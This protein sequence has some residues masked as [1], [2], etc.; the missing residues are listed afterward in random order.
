MNFEETTKISFSE[1]KAIMRGALK[2]YWR[3]GIVPAVIVALTVVVVAFLLPPYFTSEALLI[4]QPQRITSELIKKSP[5]EIK[6]EMQGLMEEISTEILSRA[7]LR[8]IIEKYDLY[9]EFQGVVGKEQAIQKF[10]QAI[11]LNP[12]VSSSGKEYVSTFSLSYT[13]QDAKTAFEVTKI[14]SDKFVEESMLNKRA[15]MQRTEEFLDSQ[16]AETRK[17]LEITEDQ[18]QKFERANFGRLPDYLNAAVARLQNLQAQID[19]NQKSIESSVQRKSQLRD[20][21]NSV[22]RTIPMPNG[23]VEVSNPQDGV[24]QL[25]AALVALRSRY[26]EQHP[27]VIATKKRL[28]ALKA[29]MAAG[30]DTHSSSARSGSVSSNPMAINIRS[31][32][33]KLE[34]EITTRENENKRLKEQVAK[35]QEDIEAMPTKDQEMIKIKR[36]YENINSQYNKLL[37]DRARVNFEADMYR[38]QAGTQIKL[39][40]PAELPVIAAGPPRALI[41][42]AGIFAALAV[43]CSIPFGLFYVNNAYKFRSDIEA[44]LGLPVF[45]VIPPIN[46]AFDAKVDERLTETGAAMMSLFFL[47][48]PTTSKSEDEIEVKLEG[49]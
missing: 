25:E 28:E 45:G 14:L 31:E 26:S 44:D 30:G 21:L 7:K 39:V 43:F 38:N 35:L 9:P 48:V 40:N 37:A 18:L 11:E 24:A 49:K 23:G 4:I 16:L 47:S 15:E 42:L 34:V 5:N 33:N 32:Q 1:I 17:K 41:A 29:Q 22:S 10:K 6:D 3:Y 2:R 13:H 27:D 12:V 36:D 19:S 8:S 20:E 46:D